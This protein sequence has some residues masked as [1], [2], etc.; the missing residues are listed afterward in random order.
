MR[1]PIPASDPFRHMQW[2]DAQIW[3]TVLAAPAAC[4]D[5]AFRER[6]HHLHLCQWAFLLMWRGEPLEPL[7]GE[8]PELPQLMAWARQYY[9]ELDTYLADIAPKDLEVPLEMQWTG[10]DQC[11]PTVAETF[12]QVTSHATH[13]R[14]QLCTLLREAG[15]TP[16][17]VD[18]ITWVWHHKPGPDWPVP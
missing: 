7:E 2:A 15:A 16:P 12:V 17:S 4:A 5:P 9:A 18:F 13:H 14:G 10:E 8:A 11:P 6:L 3:H 1:L